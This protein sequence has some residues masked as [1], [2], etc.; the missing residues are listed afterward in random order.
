MT[1]QE[2]NF[3]HDLVRF[4]VTVLLLALIILWIRSGQPT[5]TLDTTASTSAADHQ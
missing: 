1:K 3:I 2:S 5:P 4:A